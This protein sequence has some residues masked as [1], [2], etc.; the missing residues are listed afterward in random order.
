MWNK[1]ENFPN[2]EIDV[3]KVNEILELIHR[4]YKYMEGKMW[5]N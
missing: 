3:N 1:N 2:I 5:K 4:S